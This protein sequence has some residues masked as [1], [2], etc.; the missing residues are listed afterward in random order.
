M[1]PSTKPAAKLAAGPGKRKGPKPKF[2]KAIGPGLAKLFALVQGLFALLVVNSFYLIGVTI[3]ETSSGQVF[4][5]WFYLNMF[6]VHLVLGF[7]MTI[8]VMVF[9]FAHCFNTYNR[10][11]RRAVW[12]GYGLF[13]VAILLM[14]SGLV[15]TRIEGVI[16]VKDPAIR[17]VAYWTHVL[18][19]L[20]VAWL[21]V[22]HRLSGRPIRWKL[23]LRW[24]ALAAGFAAL[25]VVWQSQ[26]PRQWNVEGPASGEEYFFPSLARTASGEFIPERVLDN[27]E[28]CAE[29]HSDAHDSW[30]NS[31]HR[32]GSFN[33]PPYLASVRETRH[34]AFERDGDVQAARFCAGC[35]DPVVFFSGKFDD[36]DFDDETDSSSQSGI[37]CTA[38]HAITHVNSP[39][40]NGDY[41]IEEPVQYPF[42]FSESPALAWV[43]RQL[44]KAKP[45]FHKRTYLKPLH[46]SAEYCGACHKVHLPEELNDYKWLRGQNSY[47]SY[48]LSGVSGHG[49]SSF[50]YPEKAEENC[51]GCHMPLHE[52][53]DFGAQAFDDSGELKI[54]D[55]QFPSANTAIPH[56]LGL[57]PEVNEAHRAFND[58]VMRVDL[59]GIRPG[60]TIDGELVAP[61]RPQA[62]VLERG[63]S[64]L[65]EAVI[66]TLKMGHLFTQ[67]TSDSNQIWMDLWARDADGRVIGRSGGLDDQNR[68]DPW[69]HFVNAYVLDRDGNRI[70]RRNPQDIFVALYNH[71]IP[72]GAADVVHYGLQI[73]EDA[74]GPIEV[75]LR[76]QF[77]KFDNPYMQFVYGE[78]FVNDLPI[79]TLAEDRIQ[80]ELSDAAA[81]ELDEG[82]AVAIADGTQ[83]DDLESDA[84]QSDQDQSDSDSSEDESAEQ[85]S[86]AMRFTER[87]APDFPEWQRWNDYGIALLRKGGKSKGELRQAEEA[88]SQVEQLGRPD[89][90]LNLARVYLAQG[91]VRDDAIDALARAATFDPP[92]PP[93]TVAWL[94]GLVNKQNGFV[95]EAEANFQSVLDIDTEET[96]RRGFDF[97]LDYRVLNELG[98]SRFE[99][100][101]RFRGEADAGKRDIKLRSAIEAFEATLDIDPENVTAHHNL[102]LLYRQL[103]EAELAESHRLLHAKYKVDDNARDVAVAKAR[104]SDPAANHAAEAIVIYD[105]A[106]EGSFEMLDVGGD[107]L[108]RAEEFELKPLDTASDQKA[109]QEE[110]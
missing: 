104:A 99:Q 78:D 85:S 80:F 59:F 46:E 73:P 64:Y 67:G 55:H 108:R 94:T 16:V 38:C 28:Y 12:V 77:R 75:E 105:L 97:S 14:A 17:Q 39:R 8:P 72:P 41:T 29:C 84:D 13:A 102:Y 66:R 50:Y 110:N 34:V 24:A 82:G 19:P 58:G 93:W 98:L 89:G 74:V 51:N 86:V 43:N 10:P 7:A 96:R 103:D 63:E 54:H 71:Q 83:S 42:T 49:A 95:E 27:N 32:F 3:L 30:S 53:E 22:L 40:G 107:D 56:L 20:V 35:H 45:E 87:P 5:N 90:P 100:A 70:A 11:N 76:L 2:R 101:K 52:S 18:T 69:S 15:L 9:G 92:A 106:R 6:L 79:M 109:M 36:P 21:Y 31:V 91:T 48:L 68:V 65:L 62:P 23:G 47:D 61:L 33:N 81:D 25:L 4:Q 1:S 57:D 26:D 37:T 60:G 88:F 44:I